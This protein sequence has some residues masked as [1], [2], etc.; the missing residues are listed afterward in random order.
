V[1]QELDGADR[2]RERLLRLVEVLFDTSRARLGPLDVTPAPCDLADL[3]REQATAGGQLNACRAGQLC[4]LL[5]LGEATRTSP[6][7]PLVWY[8]E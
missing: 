3:V 7:P 1:R 6:Q 4:A 2:S 8:V 5:V